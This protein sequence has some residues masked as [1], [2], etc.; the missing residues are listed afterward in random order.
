MITS[1]PL[2]SQRQGDFS[3]L[4][5]ANGALIPIYDPSSASLAR[6]QF[7]QQHDSFDAFGSGRRG[8]HRATPAANQFGSAGQPLP[9]NNYA[10]TR[11]TTAA[12]QSFDVRLDH[13]FSTNNTAFVRH[14][15]QNTDADTPSL[16]GLPL[17]GPPTGAGT[18][19]ARNQNAGIGEI[20]QFTPSLINEARIGLN[21]QTTSLTQEDYGQNLSSQFGIPG[22]N[23]SPQTSGLSNLVVPACSASGE[24]CLRRFAWRSRIGTS[25]TR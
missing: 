17:G 15:F 1:V 21:R 4:F 13:Q 19:Q 23:L 8:D 9:F 7:P 2:T 24:A 6:T 22:I 11:T 25:A 3:S 5:G 12:V 20:Y 16:F 18:T 14:S 10:V